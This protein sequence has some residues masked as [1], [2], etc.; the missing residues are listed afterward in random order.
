MINE[1]IGNLEMS[2]KEKNLY[3]HFDNQG[4]L[5]LIYADEDKARE[6]IINLVGNAIKFTHTGGITLGCEVKDGMLITRVTD[7]GSGITKEDQDLLFKKFSQVQGN[8]ARQTGGTGLGLYI[9]KQIVEGLKGKIWLE[10]TLGKGSTF[11][12]SLPLA[13]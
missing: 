12:F 4:V 9:S 11:Y 7:T 2:A 3:L 1:V 6:V 5:P 8:Y 13:T 10:S